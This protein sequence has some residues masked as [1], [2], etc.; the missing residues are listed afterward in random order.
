MNIFATD[1]PLSSRRLDRL[2]KGATPGMTHISASSS[3]RSGDYLIAFS[4]A[5]RRPQTMPSTPIGHRP[6]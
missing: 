6:F 1:L 2:A 4:T 5:F 3:H